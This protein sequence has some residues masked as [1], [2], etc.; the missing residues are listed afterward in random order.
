MHQAE[1]T[2][3]ATAEVRGRGQTGGVNKEHCKAGS[4]SPRR[5]GQAVKGLGHWLLGLSS[6]CSQR[7]HQMCEDHTMQSDGLG[8]GLDGQRAKWV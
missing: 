1:G 5:V 8:A 4:G 7:E 2:E 3:W 6:L